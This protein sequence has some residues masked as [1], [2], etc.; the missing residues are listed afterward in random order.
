M[1][2]QVLNFQLYRPALGFPVNWKKHQN[3]QEQAFNMLKEISET[4]SYTPAI[5]A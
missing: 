4:R 3:N 1:G 5:G 2:F